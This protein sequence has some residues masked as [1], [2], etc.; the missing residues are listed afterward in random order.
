MRLGFRDELSD[1]GIHSMPVD[2][3]AVHGDSREDEETCRSADLTEPTE[4]D[5]LRRVGVRACEVGVHE[6]L[7]ERG[8][9]LSPPSSD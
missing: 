1:L 8:G 9:E 6:V 4:T 3:G 2:D 5:K 7:Q